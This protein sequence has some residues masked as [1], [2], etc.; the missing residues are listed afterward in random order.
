MFK[1][2]TEQLA[3]RCG[4]GVSGGGSSSDPI[5]LS[6]DD[7]EGP[8]APS[9]PTATDVPSSALSRALRIQ[10]S[11]IVSGQPGLFT[12]QPI[13]A[14]TFVCVYVYDRVLSDAQVYTMPTEER[15]AAARYAVAG[16]APHQ[17]LIVD[18]P[19]TDRVK[20]VAAFANEPLD[21][22]TANMALHAE[23]VTIADG[24]Q[25]YVVALYTCD[26]SVSAG[27]ELTWNYGRSYASIRSSERYNAGRG[28]TSREPLE[29]ELES[30][31][32]RIVTE[33]VDFGG[34]LYHLADGSSSE[35]GESDDEYLGRAP[36]QPRRVQ[37]R[38]G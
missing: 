15:A 7:E 12:I 31:V 16:P 5:V 29:P 19:I 3:S 24:S 38:R 1:F 23:R 14:N 11:N 34:V 9:S 26:N 18:L 28:C 4:I 33:R 36:P 32:Q 35:S 17:T 20:H 21:G 6:S 25:Y 8:P 10:Q 2:T 37:P 22:Q 13:P 30:I 27:T